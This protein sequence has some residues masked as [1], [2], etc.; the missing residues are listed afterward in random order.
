M[1]NKTT[2]RGVAIFIAAV[3]VASLLAVMPATALASSRTYTLDADFD[4]GTLVG[5]EHETV[6]DQLQ[7]N[8]TTTTL[9]F[10]WVP[11]SNEGT[12]SKVD[13]VTGKELGRYRTGPTSN[14]NPSR[15]TVDLQGSCWVGNRGTGT[16]V[17]IGLSEAG[18]YN[19]TN[20]DGFMN[21]SMDLNGDGD[22]TGAEILPWGDDECVLFEV[23]LGNSGSGPRGLAIDAT[24][25]L[26]AGTWSTSEYYYIDGTTGGIITTLDV[27]PWGH[28]AYGA[29]IDGNGILW[30]A[31][32]SNHVMGINTSDLSDI[33]QIPVAHTYGLGI[34]YLGH[35]FVG[36]SQKLTK[37]NIITALPIWTKDAR[38]V[39]GVACTADN[40]VWVAGYD[41]NNQYT[42]VSRYDNNGNLI[43]TISGFNQPSGVAV[44]AAG[45]VWVADIG[46]EYIHRIDPATNT[47][48]LSK[49]IIGSG[50]HYTYSDMTGI[51][52]RSIT[53]KIGTWTV[54]FD[55]EVADMEWG[56]VSW[57][58]YEPDGTSVTVK[59]RSSNDQVTWSAWE[60]VTNGVALSTTPDG[61]YLQIVTT[62][63]I[64]SGDVSPILYDLTVEAIGGPCCVPVPVGPGPS[65]VTGVPVMTPVGMLALIGILGFVGAGVIRKRR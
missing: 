20:G 37:I 56:T 44:D 41:Q 24:N 65:G 2:R 42:G 34:D 25:N 46:S 54:D 47:I 14:G 36:G 17:K 57:N 63:Q 1:D 26:W 55:S 52:A 51:I 61:R 48:D 32:L 29:V 12:V 50:G 16:V 4:E 22:I 9:P 33:I 58:S 39:R 59:V 27:S 3:M 35:L 49:R 11:N 45:K 38:T 31:E 30:S 21:T 60:T 8:N 43:V 7:L 28:N 53:T 62:L 6:H 23:L 19:D 40:N 13:T 10:I 15:T 64:T 5:V 18:L